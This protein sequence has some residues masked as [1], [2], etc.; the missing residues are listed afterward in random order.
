M[1]G[2]GGG[3]M[4]VGS[5]LGRCLGLEYLIKYRYLCTNT[6]ERVCVRVCAC[7]CRP[8]CVCMSMLACV[9]ACL[10]VGALYVCACACA[11]P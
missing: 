4:G 8:V 2:L 10:H 7:V 5:V 6:Y 9:H 1:G 11:C 3:G